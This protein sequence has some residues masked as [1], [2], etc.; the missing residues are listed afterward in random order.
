MGEWLYYNLPMDVFTQRN[1]AV[2][3]IPLKL[4]FILKSKKKRFAT[5]WGL[6]GNIR[7]PSIARCKAHGWLPIRHNWTF[8]AI[9][10][11]WNVIR[12]N[13]SKSAFLKGVGH[14]ECKFQ[15]EGTSHTNHCWC[16]KTRVTALSCGIK[17]SVVH[18]L[19]LSQGMRVMD[20]RT[21]RITT[22]KTALE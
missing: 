10:Y 8:F 1:F 19:V 21:D 14:L 20:R 7:I 13:L 3:F 9:S 6:R 2:D 15:T 18:Y 22:P 17:I 12:W 11:G 16:Q 4:N 5:V